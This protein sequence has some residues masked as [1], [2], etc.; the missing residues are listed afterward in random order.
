MRL[1]LLGLLLLSCFRLWSQQ[2]NG[3]DISDS[4]V[5]SDKIFR[6]GPPR[7]GIPSIDKPIFLPID[8][9][10]VFDKHS[11]VLGVVHNGVA[12]AYPIGIM[13]WHEIV[14][15][16][17]AG[18]PLVVTYCPLCGS[19][20]SFEAFKNGAPIK[21][22]VS[23]LLYNSDVLLYDRTTQ[24]LW[25]QILAKAI[26]GPL[27][28]EKLKLVNTQ[29]MTL[30]S[31]K[32]LHPTSL[33]LTTQT[34]Y[35]RDYYQSPYTDY[36]LNNRTYF[37]LTHENSALPKKEWIVGIEINDHYKAYPISVL[38]KKKVRQFEDTLGGFTFTLTWDK[39]GEN[40]RAI[41]N[42]GKEIPVL[43]MFWFAWAAFH[44]ETEVLKD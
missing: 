25:S 38:A 40:I 2:L 36:H 33:I 3:F 9:Y 30:G 5:P 8:K 4:L 37:P 14:N 43:Q 41:A 16:E 39:N 32:A 22:G 21:F 1:V 44:P 17:F 15:D 13:D 12:K 35:S 42:N 34:G 6:G 31:W 20:I 23:G 19:G 26:T 18:Q 29:R 24:S 10:Q 11:E 27:K 7:D 28:G